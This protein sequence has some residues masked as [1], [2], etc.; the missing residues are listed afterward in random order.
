MTETDKFVIERLPYHYGEQ[1]LL[2]KSLKECSE[3][4][5]AVDQYI[6]K[7]CNTVTFVKSD[8]HSHIADKIANVY[9]CLELIKRAC[10]I[11]DAEI[12]RRVDSKLSKLLDMMENI[13]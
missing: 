8:L 13:D 12:S 3:L 6:R 7:P 4:I 1:L 2:T 10:I 11:D 5:Q 9:I